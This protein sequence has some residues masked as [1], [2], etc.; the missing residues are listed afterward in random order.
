MYNVCQRDCRKE[1]SSHTSIFVHGSALGSWDWKEVDKHLTAKDH[2][3]YRPTLTGL[4]KT[5]SCHPKR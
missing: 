3:V 1:R 4:G 2:T 5:L